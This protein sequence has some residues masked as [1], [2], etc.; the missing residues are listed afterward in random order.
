MD[1]FSQASVRLLANGKY[2]LLL[3]ESTGISE[4][5]PIAATFTAQDD[6]GFTLGDHFSIDN[7]VST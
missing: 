3:I 7:M 6:K 1:M 5:M 2:D 4:P